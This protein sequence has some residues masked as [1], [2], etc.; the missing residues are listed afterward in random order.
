MAHDNYHAMMSL[1]LDRALPP[2]EQCIL[3][4]HLETCPACRST[5]DRMCCADALFGQAISVAPSAD[6]TARV[7]VRVA[8]REIAR[9]EAKPWRLAAAIIT[10]L[11]AVI[12]ALGVAGLALLGEGDLVN[13]IM[14]IAVQ[15]RLMIASLG[16]AATLIETLVGAL[17]TWLGFLVAQPVVWGAAI[18]MLTLASIW[19]GLIEALKPTPIRVES[20]A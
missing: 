10:G 8:E 9:H 3:H 15:G 1:A 18:S 17:R 11:F 19:L 12:V 14:R 6:F 7:M 20:G 16:A 13:G 4:G 5:W 2:E